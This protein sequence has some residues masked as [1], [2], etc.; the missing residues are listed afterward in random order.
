M[1]KEGSSEYLF[2]VKGEVVKP[3]ES[4]KILG[5]VIDCGLRYTQHIARTA[6]KSLVADLALKRLKI[7]SL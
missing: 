5:V 3:Q 2:L 6:A 4:A 7:L 1:N